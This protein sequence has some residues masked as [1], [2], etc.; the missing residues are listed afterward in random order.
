M[1]FFDYIDL[2]YNNLTAQ[3]NNYLRLVFN[4]S[5]ESFSNA[6]PF[7]QVVSVEKEIYQ[8]NVI[9]QKNVVRNFMVDEA[10]NQKAVRNLA[11]IGGHNP[12]RAITA[13]G[14]LKMKLKSGIDIYNDIGGGRIKINDKTKI[15]NKTNGLIYTIRF[16]NSQELFEVSQSQDIY[17]NLVQGTYETYQFTGSGEIN[18]SFSVQVNEASTIDNFDVEV[19]YNNQPVTIRD[20]QFDMLRNEI[21]CFTRTGMNGGLDIFFGNGDFGF[22]PTQGVIISVTYL[23]TDGTNGIILTPQV[24][25]WQWIDDVVDMNGEPVNMDN[26]FDVYVD[27]QIGFASDGETTEFTKSVM[28]YMSRNFVLATPNQYIYTLKRLSLFSKINVYNTLDDKNFENDNKVYL[29]LVPNI[30]NYFNNNVNYFN[31]P[32]DAFTLDQEEID[33]TLTYLKMMANIPVNTVLEVIQPTISKYIMNI[34]VR[35]FQGY[36]DDGIK[37]NII[38]N[39][40]NYLSTLER[41]DRIPK[42]DIINVLEGTS[43]VDSVNVSFVSKKN[44]DYHKIKPNSGLIYGLD[45]VLGDIVV[46]SQ[47]L[48]VI[49]GGWS[50]RNY[51]YYNESLDSNGLGPINIMFVGVTE[52]NINNK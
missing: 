32:M 37:Q 25:D 38:T 41:D 35:K 10:D 1:A 31:V 47:E 42:S 22:I 21:A 7:G 49:R 24:N 50:D 13:T 30:T 39:V 40:S 9:Y 14:S 18:Q 12:T 46:D 43:G 19:K 15:K 52:E 3:I 11:R 34:Y 20:A 8:Q 23:L 44:E 5:D 6:S 33:K 51:T 36:S 2:K 16:G 4:R 29:F 28:P 45:S 26:T 27:K 17:L 48:A